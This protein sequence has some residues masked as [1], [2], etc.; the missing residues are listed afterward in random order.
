MIEPNPVLYAEVLEVYDR[1]A[2]M[3][4]TAFEVLAALNAPHRIMDRG[5]EVKA[6][7]LVAAIIG[8]EHEA[9]GTSEQDTEG[10]ARPSEGPGIAAGASQV[11]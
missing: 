1:V 9:S 5:Y 3:D 8:H 10:H 2:D 11:P 4:V 6:H 7:H